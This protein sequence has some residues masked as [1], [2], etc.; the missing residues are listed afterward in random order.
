M[1]FLVIT[2]LHQKAS[3]IEWINA[4]A[5]ENDV[6]AILFLG[7]VTDFGTCD[8]GKEILKKFNKEVYFIPGNCDPP[9]IPG[10]VEGIV[11]SVHG[12]SFKIEGL[13]FAALGGS[14]PTIFSTPF[15]LSEEEIKSTLHPLCETDMVL[16]THA[17]SYGILDEIPSGANVGSTSI[18][19]IVSEFHPIVALSGHIHEA[20]GIKSIEGTLFVNP[21]PARDG[22]AV[23]LE[24]VDGKAT[25]KA[26][27][28]MD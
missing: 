20:I 28:P 19:S 7:D 17:P 4:L 11:H 26:V 12:K 5:D 3:A 27:G 22:H 13:H 25:A 1:K 10:E 16:M 6:K 24:I 18:R 9:S 8:D 15:E 21:G 2:D 14:N 23:L